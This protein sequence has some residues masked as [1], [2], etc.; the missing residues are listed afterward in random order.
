M[1]LYQN[2]EKLNLLPKKWQIQE[3]DVTLNKD[4]FLHDRKDWFI[5]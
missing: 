4:S 5:M 2:I 1:Y 3:N